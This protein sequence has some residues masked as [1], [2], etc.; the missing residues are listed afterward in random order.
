MNEAF[1]TFF[2]HDESAVVNNT[3]NL[4]FNPFADRVFF[5]NQ[6][7]GIFEPLLVTQRNPLSFAVKAQHDDVDLVSDLEILGW[8]ADSSP[9]DVG[10]VEEPV[11]ATEVDEDPVVGEILHHA[12]DEFSFLENLHGLLF[13]QTL[14]ILENRL[15]RQHDIRTAAIEGNDASLDFLVEIVLETPVRQKVHQG[16][17]Q[18]SA[19]A[20]VDRQPA[21]DSFE[22]FSGHL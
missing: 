12:F 21:F 19:Y 20:D 15:S 18:K 7:P 6:D 4:A 3:D 10:D 17:R 22:H 5:G 11:E 13:G 9:G 16:S 14:F 1:N 8:V 2:E